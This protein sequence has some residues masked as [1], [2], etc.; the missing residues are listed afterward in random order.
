MPAP[1]PPSSPLSQSDSI[2]D[3][4]LPPPLHLNRSLTDPLATP[5]ERINE[6]QRQ[7]FHRL[8][9]NTVIDE[10]NELSALL[11]H[12]NIL[13]ALL[14]YHPD[15]VTMELQHYIF[16]QW[17]MHNDAGIMACLSENYQCTKGREPGTIL[18]NRLTNAFFRLMDDLVIYK[19]YPKELYHS[20]IHSHLTDI[21]EV[22]MS[23]SLPVE[24]CD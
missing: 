15:H 11:V 20:L 22:M 4:S 16:K 5:V 10:L 8:M 12:H 9:F 6:A 2:S 23:S 1:P 19:C 18:R 21:R 24:S 14:P 13:L 3:F 17:K 7:Q